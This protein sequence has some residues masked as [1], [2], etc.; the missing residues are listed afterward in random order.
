MQV[1]NWL[2]QQFIQACQWLLEK[3]ASGLI[4]MTGSVSRFMTEECPEAFLLFGL[5]GV[6]FIMAN[7]KEKG[8]RMI[9][10]S[11]VSFIIMKILGVSL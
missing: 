1:L 9:N 10:L 8:M 2:G 3:G 6:F 7:A 4:G 5:I 11:F